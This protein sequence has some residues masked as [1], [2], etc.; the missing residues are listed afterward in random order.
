MS[1]RRAPTVALLTDFGTRDV[2]V[3]VVKAVILREAPQAQV[4][5]LT[6]D[7]P[8]GDIKTAAFRLW[9]A[10]PFLPPETVVLAV[11]DPGVG[12]ARKAVIVCLPEVTVVC[13]D[14]GLTTYW[15]AG[16]QISAAGGARGDRRGLPDGVRAFEI[17]APPEEARASSATFH[18]RDVFAPAAARLLAGVAPEHLGS[19]VEELV[20]LALPLLAVSPSPPSVRG[21]IL[22]TDRFGN[23]ASSIGLLR[24]EQAVLNLEPWLPGGQPVSL[25]ID[26]LRVNLAGLSDIPFARTYAEVPAGALLAYIGSDGLLEIGANRGRAVDLLRPPGSGPLE[27][28]EIVLSR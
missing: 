14:N 28:T 2:F 19:P 8:P 12:T 7:V 6:H 5:D 3:G 17:A 13:P 10:V 20:R 4:I 21:E 1:R 16:R 22:S 24:R 27:G 9:Q 18:G 26:G 11:V 25:P 15:L 23:L